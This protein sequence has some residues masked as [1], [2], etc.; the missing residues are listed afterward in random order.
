LSLYFFYAPVFKF[1]N[2]LNKTKDALEVS[3]KETA[4]LYEQLRETLKE[5]PLVEEVKLD[6]L[7]SF[8]VVSWR[9]LSSR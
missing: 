8:T 4:S 1:K 3:L 6:F 7:S 5:K 9:V 2:E